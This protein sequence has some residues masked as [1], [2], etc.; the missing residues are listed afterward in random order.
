MSAGFLERFPDTGELGRIGSDAQV[1]LGAMLDRVGGLEH[2]Q[3]GSPLTAVT[4][5]LGDLAGTLDVD[6][7]GLTEQLPQVL[8]TIR[9]ALPASALEY[10]EAI[11]QAYSLARDLLQSGPLAEQ[12]AHGGSLQDVALAVVNA[13]L[14]T[15]DKQIES[16]AE[17][18]IDPDTL[19]AV[20]EGLAGFDRF[21]QD[22]AAHKGDFLPFLAQNLIGVGAD[23]LENPL[24]AA[25]R[26]VAVL[27][28]VGAEA[29]AA[30]VDPALQASAGA[31]NGLRAAL[32]G[33]D[34]S[35]V[36]VYGEIEGRFDALDAA[37]A[38]I[39]DAVADRYDA[40]AAAIAAQPWDGLMSTYTNALQ[41]V[42][43]GRVPSVDDG[44]KAI[45]G[46]LDDLS[47]RLGMVIDGDELTGQ[48]DLLVQ[49]VQDTLLTSGVGA[50]RAMLEDAL[51]EL[52]DAIAQVPTEEIQA[53]VDDM[54][55]QVGDELD[56]FDAA[57]ITKQ[58]EDALAEAETF[59]TETFNDALV[60]QAKA[61]VSELLNAVQSLPLAD[62]T[63]R[64][65]AALQQ[66]ADLIA[67]IEAAI[68]AQLD[69][70]EELLA[71]L[72]Q[73]S[74][75]PLADEVITEIEDVAKRLKAMSP[76]A[77][78]PAE[79]LALSAALA[80]LEAIDL[81]GQIIKGLEEGF[82]AA[83]T[84]VADLLVQLEHA[85][86]A[87]KAHVDE[88]D[89]V[90]LLGPI[91]ELVQRVEHAA[92]AVNATLLLKPLRSL[93]AKLTAQLEQLAP[94]RL[95][96][97]LQK[98]Y[99]TVVDALDRLDPKQWVAPLDDLYAEID[100]LI[101]M[102]DVTPLLGELDDRRRALL[103]QVRKSLLDAIDALELPSPLDTLLDQIRP[104][105][106]HFA[107]GL[108]DD[109]GELALMPAEIDL[110]APMKVLDV[111]FDRLLEMTAS[112]PA[113]DLTSAVNVLR[114]GLGTGIDALD[115]HALLDRLRQGQA[116]LASL[117][118]TR[119]LGPVLSLPALK[120]SFEASV[121]TAPPARASD[122][123]A[124]RARFDATFALVDTSRADSRTQRLRATHRRL[125]DSLA[126]HI[127]ALDSAAA[128]AAYGELR[129]GLER[130]V[131]AFL[132]S[133]APLTHDD[134]I[135]GLATLRPSLLAAPI[136]AALERFLAQLQPL[137]STVAE[138]ADR[139]LGIVR[140]TL[141]LIDPLALQD[142]VA[143]IYD[144]IRA[145]ARILDPAKLAQA[146]DELLAKLKA[147]LEALD[148]AKLGAQLDAAYTRTLAALTGQVNGL[149]DDIGAA[150][151]EE[152]RTI[153]DAIKQVVNDIET[154]LAQVAGAVHEVVGK[155]EDL[156]LTE[157][158][159]RLKR[160]LDN[161]AKSFHDELE[162][163]RNAFD[164]M[165]KAI[166][167]RG[168]EPAGAIAA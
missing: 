165:L 146:A 32:D 113:D 43:L 74:F 133:P 161:L 46:V 155:V 136:E 166:P 104:V 2:D 58:I 111:P 18:L 50:A 98:P 153:R 107:G 132:R 149:L 110:A 128:I 69:K 93:L 147:P 86:G 5:A 78:S 28:P 56:Q 49:S 34:A 108:F 42:D 150:I 1:A 159:A 122:V 22:Y 14:G 71:Q 168:G 84:P 115:P 35:D 51:G 144:T 105:L 13:A 38:S 130:L 26:A 152:L 48:V 94:H 55:K 124:V 33:L 65:E 6:T 77:L 64:L 3:A 80:I 7:S 16:L 163:V 36:A 37:V 66:A 87:V 61:A 4:G 11:E 164:E 127:A 89:P 68:G 139:L 106:E 138:A 83:K 141:A 116:L 91:H 125:T 151:D 120:V 145:K 40:L 101:A 140:S 23:A 54:L 102:V 30:E 70:L 17:N 10:V 119:V 39:A 85:L 157:F 79:R 20:R 143:A 41:A 76:S 148:P 45:V 97:P 162:R 63:S 142:A 129:T 137:E 154:F 112:I 109:P 67:E 160:L 92:D 99:D 57:T 114:T 81:E 117:D 53:A 60:E 12:L 135:A 9:Q 62:L 73:I 24:A 123:V 72:D 59:I 82:D 29:L 19:T 118:P 44:V 134:V 96:E 27:A 47:R 31:L 15:F 88:L 103:D 126:Q 100:K 158:V 8:E 90:Q 95:L 156:V 52:R 75:K 21:S 131:P 25:E 167:L 121:Q